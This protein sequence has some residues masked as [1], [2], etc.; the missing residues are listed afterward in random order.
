MGRFPVLTYAFSN[1]I[2]QKRVVRKQVISK[3]GLLRN[4]LIQPRN[5][6]VQLRNRLVQK[7]VFKSFLAAHQGRVCGVVDM[8]DLVVW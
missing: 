4:R 6:L 5:R 2:V 1:E 7:R 8:V 3:A